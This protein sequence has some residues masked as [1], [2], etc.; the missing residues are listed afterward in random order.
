MSFPKSIKIQSAPPLPF[1]DRGSKLTDEVTVDDISTRVLSVPDK[2]E[3]ATLKD[4]L[5]IGMKYFRAKDKSDHPLRADP[6]MKPDDIP[7][8]AEVFE[9][10]FYCYFLLLTQARK[11]GTHPMIMKLNNFHPSSQS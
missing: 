7:S 9:S 6:T 1:L 10:V 5:T 8:T 11:Q 4:L 2:P 3:Q